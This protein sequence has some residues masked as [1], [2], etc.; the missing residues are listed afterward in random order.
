MALRWPEEPAVPRLTI[1]LVVVPGNQGALTFNHYV[2]AAS[3]LFPFG[4]KT[5]SG[6][7][8]GTNWN[9]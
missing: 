9:V 3:R 5:P 8:T 7:L 4:K 1:T 2:A 6:K